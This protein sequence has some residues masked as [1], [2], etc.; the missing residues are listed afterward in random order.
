MVVAGLISVVQG[1]PWQMWSGG[2]GIFPCLAYSDGGFLD[3]ERGGRLVE[4]ENARAEVHRSPPE[5]LPTSRRPSVTRVMPSDCISPTATSPANFL[6][7]RRRG[8]QRFVGSAP[9]K[10]DRPTLISGKAPPN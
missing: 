1:R 4:D 3:A 8:P 9:T 7:K 2:P 6:S 10:N 5:R